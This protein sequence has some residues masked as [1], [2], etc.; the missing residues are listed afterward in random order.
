M[1]GQTIRAWVQV[2]S[3][4]GLVGILNARKGGAPAKLTEGLIDL[5]VEI[6]TREPISL[7]QIA[8]R[9]REERPDAPQF[10]LD[11]LSIRLRERGMSY[12]R[13]RH[14]LKKRDLRRLAQQSS[15]RPLLFA[16]L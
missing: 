5:T 3:E 12:K 1:N 16:D 4:R 8:A 2:W 9:L 15:I 13:P 6:A 14:S 7:T 10:S 11:T